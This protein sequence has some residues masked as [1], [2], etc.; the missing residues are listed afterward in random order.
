M[1]KYLLA[2]IGLALLGGIALL[3]LA[4][5]AANAGEAACCGPAGCETGCGTS[6]CPTCCGYNECHCRNECCPHCGCKL[7]PVCQITCTTKK[8]TEHKYCCGCKEICVPGV[9]GICGKCNPCCD[10]GGQ[11][12]CDCHCRV[13]EVH[14]LMVFPATKERPVKQCTVQWVCPNCSGGSNSAPA[15]VPS[16]APAPAAPPPAPGAKS[17]RLPPPPKTTDATPLPED[18]R[19]AHAAF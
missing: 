16:T 4:P 18:I 10:N 14:K 9:T 19:T 6:A 15:A 3:G 12:N 11:E 5:A 8:T 2:T 1:T 13:H 7:V 17:S